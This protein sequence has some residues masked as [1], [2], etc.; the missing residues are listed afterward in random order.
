MA[1]RHRAPRRP[2]RR[3]IADLLRPDAPTPGHEGGGRRNAEELLR[4][5]EQ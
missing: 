2:L 1:G 3:R 4:L 5:M